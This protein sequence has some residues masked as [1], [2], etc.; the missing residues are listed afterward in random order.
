MTIPLL[1][2]PQSVALVVVDA[3]CLVCVRQTRPGAPEPTLE[4]PSGKL[5]QDETPEQ[6]AVRELAEECGLAAATYERLGSFWV[7]PAY[8]TEQTHVFEAAN[9]RPADG[10]TPDADEDIEVERVPLASAWERLSDGTSL[11]ALALWQNRPR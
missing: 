3:D 6:A 1:E 4:L 10:G 5:E 2:H 11:A 9:V 8:S 7:V